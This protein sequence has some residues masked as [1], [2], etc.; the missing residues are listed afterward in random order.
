MEGGLSF[1]YYCLNR[2]K[3]PSCLSFQV[4]DH[5]SNGKWL[6]RD[7]AMPRDLRAKLASLTRLSDVNHSLEDM[8]S[9]SSSC[10]K[11]KTAPTSPSTRTR[12]SKRSSTNRPGPSAA[13]DDHLGRLPDEL[14]LQVLHQLDEQ[15]AG[16]AERNRIY[17]RLSLINRRFG[18]VAQEVLYE[19]FKSESGR[20]G[21]FLRTLVARPD[22]ATKVKYVLWDYNMG[23]HTRVAG[24]VP[25]SSD[26]R[27]MRAS[28]TRLGIPWREH[29]LSLYATGRS[30]CLLKLV[31]LHTPNVRCLD[32]VDQTSPHT[33]FDVGTYQSCWIQLFYPAT[34][35]KLTSQGFPSQYQHL[36]TLNLRMGGMKMKYIH[37]I[38]R[39]P[40]LRKLVLSGAYAPT[41]VIDEHQ[42]N[43]FGR[44]FEQEV[45]P[46]STSPVVDL[47][48]QASFMSSKCLAQLIR[49]FRALERLVFC[50]DT[51]YYYRNIAD[52]NYPVIGRALRRHKKTLQHLDLDDVSDRTV[53]KLTEYPRGNLGSFH[54]FE[55]LQILGAPFESFPRQGQDEHTLVYFSRLLPKTLQ[56]LRLTVFEDEEYFH[57]CSNSLEE[58][59][60][61][62]IDAVPDLSRIDIRVHRIVQMKVIQ[63]W[64]P[65]LNFVQDS[66]GFTIMHEGVEYHDVVFSDDEDDNSEEDE[67]D[68]IDSETLSMIEEAVAGAAAAVMATMLAFHILLMVNEH[69]QTT[70]SNLTSI[71]SIL[72]IVILQLSPLTKHGRSNTIPLSRFISLPPLGSEGTSSENAGDTCLTNIGSLLCITITDTHRPLYLPYYTHDGPTIYHSPFETHLDRRRPSNLLAIVPEDFRGASVVKASNGAYR[73]H[74]LRVQYERTQFVS[75][76]VRLMM[77]QVRALG[78]RVKGGLPFPAMALDFCRLGKRLRK[79]DNRGTRNNYDTYTYLSSSLPYERIQNLPRT[80]IKIAQS[81]STTLVESAAMMYAMYR[82]GRVGLELKMCK[83]V[84]KAQDM[85]VENAEL[86]GETYE[87]GVEKLGAEITRVE[88]KYR[89]KFPGLKTTHSNTSAG[90]SP[91]PN[92]TTFSNSLTPVILIHHPALTI[93]SCYLTGKPVFALSSREVWFD[94]NIESGG[95]VAYNTEK[96]IEKVYEKLGS[97]A[98]ANI[99]ES[100][101]AR[102]EVKREEFGEEGAVGLRKKVEEEIG[103]YEY[104][105]GTNSQSRVLRTSYLLVIFKSVLTTHRHSSSILS[106]TPMVVIAR[107]CKL[108]LACLHPLIPILIDSAICFLLRLHQELNP[109]GILPRAIRCNSRSVKLAGWRN[110][111]HFTHEANTGKTIHLRDFSSCSERN[112]HIKRNPEY[113]ASAN[114]TL[115]PLINN[116]LIPQHLQPRPKQKLTLINRARPPYHR[117]PSS[118]VAVIPW[119]THQRKV[120]GNNAQ[121]STSRYIPFSDHTGTH[122]DA[123]KHFDPRLGGSASTGSPREF[124]SSTPCLNVSHAGLHNATTVQDMEGSLVKS[125]QEIIPGDIELFFGSSFCMDRD[126]P[127]WQHDFLGLLPIAAR[128]GCGLNFQVHNAYAERG[129][130]HMEGLDNLEALYARGG[131]R[132]LRNLFEKTGVA[133]S[134]GREKEEKVG[135]SGGRIEPLSADLSSCQAGNEEFGFPII[136]VIRYLQRSQLIQGD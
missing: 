104:L 95:E 62:Y 112:N 114:H 126:D 52:V 89:T 41:Y 50:Y 66:I 60:K 134:H 117:A 46:T 35:G 135:L 39:H 123:L 116:I 124:Y 55:K 29:L 2:I 3:Y 106:S 24:Y 64:T 67:G 48:I 101:G 113:P 84:Q 99:I 91:S 58:F 136:A 11:R 129:V 133:V 49:A 73:P 105:K 61:S 125:G 28:L 63:L 57:T 53:V 8:S 77:P 68:D 5:L 54:D 4:C 72:A 81:Y 88:E 12:P 31:L 42:E 87:I 96:T 71:F 7:L 45:C 9:S 30:V 131:Y 83:G 119:G 43:E 37:A 69:I 26:R 93:P 74:Q 19:T 40:S 120:A 128:A 100:R 44:P 103:V 90:I 115:I 127:R 79:T 32:V 59:H 94:A 20:P 10:R 97:S 75:R 130:M 18:S 25:S 56:Q 86:E 121:S 92:P 122:I 51:R 132:L 16:G 38:L 109:L 82:P 15:P 70:P 6:A 98:E 47:E 76:T 80:G 27:N 118:S 36:H 108:P 17:R 78:S 34:P 65:K 14:L 23:D 85:L 107:A 13:N 111:Y 21:P 110:P 102:E 1:N 33:F 22:L